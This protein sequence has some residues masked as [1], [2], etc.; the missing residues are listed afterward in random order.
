MF[1]LNK[2]KMLSIDFSLETL[3]INNPVIY[4]ILASILIV[5]VIL[6]VLVIKHLRRDFKIDND[7]EIH[8]KDNKQDESN[9]KNDN[10]KL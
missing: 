2:V 1:G 7:I 10:D 9:K 6:I 8:K 3:V 5:S 4:L